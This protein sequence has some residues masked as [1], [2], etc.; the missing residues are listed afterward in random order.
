MQMFL[1][2]FIVLCLHVFIVESVDAFT[3]IRHRCAIIIDQSYLSHCPL[4]IAQN[5]HLALNSVVWFDRTNNS[6]CFCV[7]HRP[8]FTKA[9][10]LAYGCPGASGVNMRHVGTIDL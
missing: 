8:L 10:Y 3:F 2:Y 5:V 4:P 6:S 9:A 1:L 7:A